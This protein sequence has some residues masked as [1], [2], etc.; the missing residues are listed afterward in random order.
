MISFPTTLNSGGN[1]VSLPHTAS[2]RPSDVIKGLGKSIINIAK[3]SIFGAS[4]AFLS[5]TNASSADPDVTRLPYDLTRDD[6]LITKNIFNWNANG[7]YP[8][9]QGSPQNTNGDK[10]ATTA[11]D[12]QLV[13][14]PTVYTIFNTYRYV[15]RNGVME[16]TDTYVEDDKGKVERIGFN[17]WDPKTL[18]P[19]LF[20]PYY[21]I[22]YIGPTLNTPLRDDLAIQTDEKGNKTQYSIDPDFTDC[23]I[24]KLCELSKK[25]ESELGQARYKY[26]DFMYCKDLGMPN[27]R[28]ITLRR[29]SMPIGD[30][31]MGSAPTKNNNQYST[32]GD[33]GRL[34]AYFDT[35]D[36]KLEN[37]L[38]YSVKAT[39]KEMKSEIQEKKSQEDDRQS[40]LGMTLNTMS[41]NY[42]SMYAASRTGSNNLFDHFL[43]KSKWTEKLGGSSSW[44][45]N[46][47]IFT[48]YD[49]HKIYEPVNTIRA[50]QMYEGELQFANEFTLTFN[51]TLRSYDNINPKAAMLDLLSNILAVTYRRGKF[52]GGSKKING[53]QPNNA[54]WKKANNIIDNNWGKIGGFFSN[55]LDGGFDVQGIFGNLSNFLQGAVQQA[56]AVVQNVADKGKGVVN[57]ISKPKNERNQ[58]EQATVNNIKKFGSSLMDMGKAKLKNT[59]GRP[60]LYAFNSLLTGE[61]TGL[62]HVTIGNPRNPIAVMGNMIVTDTKITQYGPLGIDDFPTGIKVEVSLK[63]ARPRDMIDIQKMYTRGISSIYQNIDNPENMGGRK[64]KATDKTVNNQVNTANKKEDNNQEQDF[65]LPDNVQFLTDN[66]ENALMYIGEFDQQ[67]I[68][69]NASEIK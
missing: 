18:A 20:N 33:I 34:V 35:E 39:W 22:Q 48:N 6:S 25:P 52:W 11:G 14:D 40:M 8:S 50:M 1:N 43:G 24:S 47:E 62:W 55:L 23:S 28:L 51:Y 27:N 69:R 37:I 49:Q 41:S 16:A 12:N 36:N 66:S 65:D 5:G 13:M 58:Q 31:I 46:N 7:I 59:L 67:R 29:Y 21:G 53:P 54:G 9:L 56:A 63:H 45:E 68:R 32:P 15:Y 44:Y 19:S 4:K 57:A 42:R 10:K 26:S 3:N 64:K 60:Q 30:I 38:N 61:D 17:Y 2:L